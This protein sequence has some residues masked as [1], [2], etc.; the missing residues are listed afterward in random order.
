MGTPMWLDSFEARE[1]KEIDLARL[2]AAQYD[3]GSPGHL[4]LKIIAKLA[5]L[6]DQQSGIVTD[7][8][9]TRTLRREVPS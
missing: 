9:I 7:Y 6:L 4:H 1:Q 3:H 8:A 2:Y 5:T